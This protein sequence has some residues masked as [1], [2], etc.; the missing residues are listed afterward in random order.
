MID[1]GK[2]RRM[3]RH[4]LLA[5]RIPGRRPDRMWGGPGNGPCAV[6]G[7]VM[8]REDIGLEVEFW[9]TEP[10]MPAASHQFHVRCFGAW[11][12]EWRDGVTPEDGREG[13]RGANS[14]APTPPPNGAGSN[15]LRP[16]LGNGTIPDR[17]RDPNR[18]G[19]PQ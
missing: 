11:E 3:A 16:H 1:E 9:A 14:H 4:A 17:E 12:G 6:C 5:R 13:D 19:D 10:G 15:G 2:L 7:T 18:P 8:T